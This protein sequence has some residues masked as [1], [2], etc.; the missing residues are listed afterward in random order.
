MNRDG[1]K[2]RRWRQKNP[3]QTLAYDARRRARLKGIPC[4]ITAA[5]VKALLDAG[6]TCAYC[7]APL[8]S[9]AGGIQPLTITL[10]RVIPD[11]GYTPHNT[12]LCCHACNCAKAEHTPATLRAWADRIE[13]VLRRKEQ[14]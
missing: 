2:Q 4:T 6:W 14:T 8:G 7:D 11:L 1:G 9:F 5:D 3:H 12:V 13:A 10:D